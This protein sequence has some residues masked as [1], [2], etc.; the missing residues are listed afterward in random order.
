MSKD[1][2][3]QSEIDS[4]ISAVSTGDIEEEE[5]KKEADDYK[6]YDFR[7]PTKFSKEQMRTLKVI[8]DNYCRI[9][10]N[11]LT[12]FLRVP[13]KM[14][15]VSVSQVTYEE[16]MSSISIPTLVTIFNM[17]PESDMGIALLETNPSCAFSLI[18]L[19]FGGDGATVAKIR[20]LTDIELEV[21]RF[22][23]GKMLENLGYVW[24]GVAQLDPQIE[25]LDTNPH[26]NQVIASSETVALIS[27]D[28][29]I[30]DNTSV[31]NLCFPYI[32]LEKVLSSLTAQH[33]FN[34]YQKTSTRLN[35][36]DLVSIVSKTEVEVKV[37]LGN[38]YVTMEDFLQLQ[39]GDV[40]QLNQKEGMPLQVM[41]EDHPLIWGQPGIGDGN[42]LAVRVSE[43]MQN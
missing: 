39:E 3:T 9:L 2:L 13:V 37:I 34:E 7:R 16:F 33:W 8:H 14:E 30:K 31:M 17:A 19:N 11:F 41:V 24:K 5:M 1:V 4:L 23:N 12:A 10:G 22:L 28:I 38:T 29:T 18:D 25:T 20:E 15:V 32:S 36:R 27:M 21:M 40:L 6:N 35:T 26:F 42:N 43:I